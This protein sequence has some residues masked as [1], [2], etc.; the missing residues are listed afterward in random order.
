[1]GF[2]S[3]VFLGLLVTIAVTFGECKDF[4]FGE[5]IESY[6]EKRQDSAAGGIAGATGQIIQV[7]SDLTTQYKV[8]VE[9]LASAEIYLKC[10]SKQN[11]MGWHTLEEGQVIWKSIS[12]F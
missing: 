12:R 8:V 6:R 7:I 4:N 5:L 2:R 10:A 11:D 1:M 3:A 9:N